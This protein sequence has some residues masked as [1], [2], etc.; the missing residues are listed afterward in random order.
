M[1]HS[2]GPSRLLVQTGSCLGHHIS[3]ATRTSPRSLDLALNKAARLFPRSACEIYHR[4]RDANTP[5]LKQ[6]CPENKKNSSQGSAE[7]LGARE[8]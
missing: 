7:A 1:Q 8:P 6:C 5:R 2:L 4:H 3:M